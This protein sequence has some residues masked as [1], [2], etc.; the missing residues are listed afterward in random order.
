MLR[1]TNDD[2]YFNAR[3]YKTNFWYNIT[4]AFLFIYSFFFREFLNY[5]MWNARLHLMTIIFSVVSEFQRTVR[6]IRLMTTTYY[7]FVHIFFIFFLFETISFR[8]EC[9][10]W[11]RY[12]IPSLDRK[13]NRS[14][15]LETIIFT[16]SQSSGF[17]RYKQLRKLCSPPTHNPVKRWIASIRTRS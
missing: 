5:I 15:A 4:P 10:T 1:L 17:V 6:C 9:F 8:A 3:A 13:P 11:Y 14:G 12:Y 16:R 7:L 2:V